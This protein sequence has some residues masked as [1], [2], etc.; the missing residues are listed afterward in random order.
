VAL[1]TRLDRCVAGNDR[2]LA[3]VRV[4]TEAEEQK[5]AHKRQREQLRE[6]R[7][8]LAAQ[9]RSLTLLHGRRE[10][11]HW[12]KADRWKRLEPELAAWLVELLKVFRELILAVDQA[13]R[14]LR[15]LIRVWIRYRSIRD[16]LRMG[17]SGRRW[18]TRRVR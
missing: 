16:W 5:R 17:R 3:V 10:T 1:A 7:L 8:S 6:Q 2:A 18:C 4:L 12:R 13:V 9:G 11:N 14:Q 15:L